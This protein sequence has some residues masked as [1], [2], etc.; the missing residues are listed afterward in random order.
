MEVVLNKHNY[1]YLSASTDNFN[2]LQIQ[3]IKFLTFYDPMETLLKLKNH[4]VRVI[5]SCF[6]SIHDKELKYQLLRNDLTE[7]LGT[8]KKWL[9]QTSVVV[10]NRCLIANKA[11]YPK[12]QMA[13]DEL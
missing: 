7:F 13:L 4:T 1:I 11:H 2:I 5:D 6:V 8:T 3:I 9:H 12:T 10:D